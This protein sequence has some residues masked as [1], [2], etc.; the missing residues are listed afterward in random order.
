MSTIHR[1]SRCNKE[2]IKMSLVKGM[3]YRCCDIIEFGYPSFPA[4]KLEE[5]L[6]KVN[7]NKDLTKIEVD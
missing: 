1:C 2:V 5:N 6:Q 3:C 7:T 4:Y